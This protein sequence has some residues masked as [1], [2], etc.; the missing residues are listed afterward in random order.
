[1]TMHPEISEIEYALYVNYFRKLVG[2]TLPDHKR[3]GF[4]RKLAA[5][6]KA[7][8]I[9]SYAAFF[10]YI[11]SPRGSA[12]LAWI[13]NLLT[14]DQSRFFRGQGQLEHFA[15]IIV[16]GLAIRQRA[17]RK[18][19]IWSAGCSRGQEPYT[20]AMI[21]AEKAREVFAWDFKI[22]ATDVDSDS[23]RAASLGIYG[24]ETPQEVPPDL[25]ARYFSTPRG[26]SHPPYRVKAILRNRVIFRKL[27]LINSP[28][29]I[30]GPFQVILCRNVM[31]Y[32]DAATKRNIVS[33]FYRLLA[34]DGYLFL[35]QTESL[36][37][38]DERF[39]LVGQAVY[40]KTRAA[41]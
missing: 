7:L 1:M 28:Y 2:I 19:R 25:L 16:P 8:G 40:R 6:M 10:R 20:V 29:P 18:L 13:I 14:I 32:F 33:E 39:S 41:R 23:L 34:D 27:N 31:I 3:V 35:G 11:G 15:D 22:L 26:K 30:Q 4:G 36:F 9:P 38:I 21:L 37:G 17:A 24:A 12:E 5:R